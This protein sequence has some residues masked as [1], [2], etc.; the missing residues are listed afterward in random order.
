MLAEDVLTTRFAVEGA[1][2]LITVLGGIRQELLNMGSSTAVGFGQAKASLSE[3]TDWLY[4]VRRAQTAMRTEFRVTHA[5]LIEGGRLLSDFGAIGRN[6][7]SMWQA[8]TLAQIRVADAARDIRSAQ[9]DVTI[10]QDTL[11]RAMRSGTLE[12]QMNLQLQLSSAQSKVKDSTEALTKAQNDNIVGY[13]GMALQMGSI[14]GRLPTMALH[15]KVLSGLLIAK[16]GAE[17]ADNAGMVTSVGLINAQSAG[18]ALQTGALGFNAAALTSRVGV[19]TVDNM[20]MTYYNAMLIS[21]TAG[22]ATETG[23]LGASTL[24]RWGHVAAIGA[25]NAAL[26]IRNALMGPVGWAILAGAAVVGGAYLLSQQNNQSNKT[27]NR[28]TAVYNYTINVSSPGGSGDD[29]LDAIRR[30]GLP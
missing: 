28:N 23:A 21:Q 30:K 22:L 26:T 9:A 16:A 7:V 27:E 18:V 24:A 2:D 3:Y 12:Q 29:I 11:N 17:T 19:E 8:Y 14:I 4:T 20:Q 5:D 15:I 6:V 25:E 10:T 1:D 13:A